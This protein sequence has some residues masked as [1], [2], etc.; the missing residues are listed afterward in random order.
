[1][2]PHYFPLGAHDV[3]LFDFH[4]FPRYRGRGMNPLLVRHIL[5]RLAADGL[6]RAFIE[7]AEWNR[8]QLSSLGKTPFRRF[9]RARKWTVLRRTVVCWANGDTVDPVKTGSR[10]GFPSQPA[11]HGIPDILP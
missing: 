9:G 8:A 7:A 5:R 1:M 11:Q 2:E 10:H 3:H 6:G 4:V